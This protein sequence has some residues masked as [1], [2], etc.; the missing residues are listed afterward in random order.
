MVVKVRERIMETVE[1]G[2]EQVKDAKE[3]LAIGKKAGIDL[4][5]EETDL[6]QLETRL[7]E[8]KSAAKEPKPSK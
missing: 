3:I 2:E 5:T 8:L 7:K 1:K 6:I 4:A